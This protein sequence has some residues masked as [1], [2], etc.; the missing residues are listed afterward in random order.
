VPDALLDL[1]GLD[2]QVHCQDLLPEV[3][4]VEAGAEDDLVEPL[5]LGQREPRRQQ[6]EADRRVAGLAAQPL[7]RAR[8]DV[9]VIERQLG[10]IVEREPADAH[11]IGRRADPVI[12]ELGKRV[13]RHGDDALARIAAEPNDRHPDANIAYR[14][15]TGGRDDPCVRRNHPG[16]DPSASPM[17][18]DRAPEAG[19]ARPRCGPPRSRST[20]ATS[21]SGTRSSSGAKR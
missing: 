19:Y 16:R 11:R 10:Q 1:V 7:V 5:Q 6:L 15:A 2:Q 9:V 17:A 20:I 12:A 14:V 4:L 8:D 3:A 13:V 21:G 18:Y